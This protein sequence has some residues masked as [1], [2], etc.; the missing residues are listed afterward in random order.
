MAMELEY[1]FFGKLRDDF[2]PT[3][4][5]E[6]VEI[7]RQEQ[8]QIVSEHDDTPG[9]G[10]YGALRVR[11]EKYLKGVSRKP[12]KITFAV[13]YSTTKSPLNMVTEEYEFPCEEKMFNAM[14]MISPF[15]LI[16]TRYVLSRDGFD[17]E[18]DT[19]E[20]ENHK[21]KN[22]VK[23]D[24]EVSNYKVEPPEV[25][26]IIT[27]I[28][29]SENRSQ[30]DDEFISYLYNNVWGIFNS[31]NILPLVNAEAES[32]IERDRKM[33]NYSRE[34]RKDIISKW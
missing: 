12:E 4:H 21:W 31:K 32:F 14:R 25:S 16:K 27:D 15:G 8:W 3:M 18:I 34:S 2:I 9:S 24:I 10:P 17:I 7:I 22:W 11:H 33:A 23:I 29:R 1:V 30:K 13:K 5:K 19:Y 28:I 26:D 20:T 6:A